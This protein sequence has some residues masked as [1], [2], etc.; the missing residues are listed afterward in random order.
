MQIDAHE[1]FEQDPSYDARY[2]FTLLSS[3]VVGRDERVFIL[4][5]NPDEFK[6]GEGV[7]CVSQKQ[8][9]DRLL[10]VINAPEPPPCARG[11]LYYSKRSLEDQH[12]VIAEHWAP[13][14]RQ[15]SR[16]L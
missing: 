10:E 13:A 6:V 4:R 2:D 12:P 14:V 7:C 8:R 3:A 1:N 15:L 9:H 16:A 11:F 5:Y